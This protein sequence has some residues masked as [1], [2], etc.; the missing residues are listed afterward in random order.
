MA[1]HDQQIQDLAQDQSNDLPHEL[2]PNQLE[3]QI[4]R[5]RYIF[6]LP[7]VATFVAAVVLML[8]G[9]YET[10]HVIFTALTDRQGHAL[11]TLRLHFIETLD[12]FLL[13]TILYVISGGF[14]QLTIGE[15]GQV[16][17]WLKVSSVHD[18]E[19]LLIGVIIT[20]LGVTGLAAVMSW[21]GQSNL[22]PFGATIALIIAALAFFLGRARH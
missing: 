21:D 2:P 8:F 12:V 11:E 1:H 3:R 20:L 9:F 13:A 22:L 19:V 17:P 6:I 14:L 16:A 15:N 7:I 5:T 18:L 4:P 10:F